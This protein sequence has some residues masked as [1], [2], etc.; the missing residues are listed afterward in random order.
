MANKILILIE[1]N[2]FEA[3]L[4]DS[5]TGKAIY[6]ALPIRA[7]VQRWGGG[8]IFQYTGEL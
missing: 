7:K 1:R 2:A 4:N 3:K 8:D 6:G 5:M